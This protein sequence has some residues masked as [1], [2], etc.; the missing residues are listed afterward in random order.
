MTQT[1]IG[2][3]LMLVVG[4]GVFSLA[5]CSDKRAQQ[6][7]NSNDTAKAAER[8]GAKVARDPEP[9]RVHILEL[10]MSY[11]FEKERPPVEVSAD[12]SGPNN[13]GT[14]KSKAPDLRIASAKLKEGETVAD[15]EEILAA[16]HS[17][18]GEYPQLGISEKHNLVWRRKPS[19]D[20]KTWQVWIVSVDK[21][22]KPT[23][24]ASAGADFHSVG[25]PQEPRLVVHID[26]ASKDRI[27]EQD[28]FAAC[29][30][31]PV[32]SSQHCGYTN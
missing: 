17:V 23:E 4:V 11:D 15:S 1:R 7:A 12:V 30:F 5:G 24:L 10:A 29:L 3:R 8:T 28:T 20:P 19:S 9:D 22:V 18:K 21:H 26:P 31:D 6:D 27:E 14:P 16:I 25:S 32:C 13:H 2:V